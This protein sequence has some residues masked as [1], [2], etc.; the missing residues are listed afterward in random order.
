MYDGIVCQIEPPQS[1][2]V[3]AFS[4]EAPDCLLGVEDPGTAHGQH[5]VG[6]RH[7]PPTPTR[8]QIHAD[9]TAGNSSPVSA[10][11]LPRLGST[12]SSEGASVHA[13]LEGIGRE[14]T[15]LHCDV[16]QLSSLFCSV[17]QHGRRLCPVDTAWIHFDDSVFGLGASIHG[18]N[19]QHCSTVFFRCTI[20]M[21]LFMQRV[22]DF[23]AAAKSR[24]FTVTAGA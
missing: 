18:S 1:H 3:L 8:E 4:T 20:S 15:S 16:S 11:T 13:A 24:E 21:V 6:E 19:C 9:L 7:P 14:S 12:A 5:G 2:H 22:P 10:N 23:N 17:T